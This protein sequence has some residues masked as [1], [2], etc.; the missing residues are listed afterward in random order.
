MRPAWRSTVPA[1]ASATR[2]QKVLLEAAWRAGELDFLLTP[3]Q[4]EV[5]AAI[6]KWEERR[7]LEDR[8]FVLDSGR[9]FG[10]SYDLVER[11]LSKANKRPGCRIVYVA[12]TYDQV[13]NI[14]LPIFNDLL[15]S[16]P[17]PLRPTWV[18]SEYRFD[19]PN[20]SRIELIGLDRNPDSAR[21][22]GVDDVLFDEAGFFD[23]LEYVLFDVIW[24]Q[25]LGRQHACIVAASTPSESP[26][27]YWSRELVPLCISRGA[28]IRRTLDHAV[29]Y[30][31]EEIEAFWNGMPG[32]RN[33][34]KA[35]REFG[36]EH[37][38]DETLAIIPE[39]AEAEANIVR[40]VEPPVWRDCYV[41]LDPGF[42]DMSAAL[43]GYWH[44]LEQT[45]VIE[46]EVI[47][48]KLNSAELARLISDKERKLWGKVKRRGASPSEY[49]PQP[50]LRVSDND[51]RL[52]ADLFL[53]HKLVFVAT[54]KDQLTHQVDQV[55]V[56]VQEGK[57]AIHPRCKK[58]IAHLKAGVWKKT[59]FHHVIAG[60][61]QRQMFAREGGEF[62]HFDGIAALVYMWRN[63]HKRRNPTPPVERFV[64]DGIRAPD[65]D[66]GRQ[67]SRWAQ[68]G[69]KMRR[70]GQRYFI[71]TGRR[72]A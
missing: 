3:T 43:F 29:Q 12:P 8:I 54:Q 48:A 7:G 23:N 26:M 19:F 41:A 2:E 31:E 34:I 18:K 39:F 13:R 38:A 37:I 27:H 71:K 59:P 67:A 28:H 61:D 50:Y 4:Q 66:N 1:W 35:R 21:G 68:E 22:T 60:R 42:H 14:T 53:D 9:R 47:A 65:N 52:L 16:C 6:A 36:A 24:P 40:E 25:L 15:R 10:K 32:G 64:M 58:L 33:G 5:T 11:G 17:P 69:A 57:I 45:L 62:G 55:R 63:I 46:D 20:G 70:E 44:F 72:I 30:S 49:K 51:P 56:A